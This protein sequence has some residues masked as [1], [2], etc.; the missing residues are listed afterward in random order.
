MLNWVR[1]KG[2]SDRKLRL[3]AC[4]CARQFE[5]RLH[6]KRARRALEVAELFADGRASRPKLISGGSAASATVSDTAWRNRV[7]CIARAA[8]L[9]DAY[10]AAR[11]AILVPP[12]REGDLPVQCNLLRDI[13]GPIPLVCRP[14]TGAGSPGRM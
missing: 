12:H 3:F 5:D 1:G 6:S 14:S 8:A 9:A 10:L 4:A 2:V 13:F 11:M 7:Y